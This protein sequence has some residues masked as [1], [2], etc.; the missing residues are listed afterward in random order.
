MTV[1][2]LIEELQKDV[3]AG[4]CSLDDPICFEHKELQQVICIVSPLT[5]YAKCGDPSN[6]EGL[7]MYDPKNGTRNIVQLM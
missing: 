1:G 4:A 3:M 6:D 2:E 7:Y 5:G